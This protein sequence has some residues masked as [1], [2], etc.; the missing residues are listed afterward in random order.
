MT[1]V[2]R[3]NHDLYENGEEY[4][5]RLT[6][7][8]NTNLKI[9]FALLS[10]YWQSS[11]DG[12]NYARELKAIA[13][14]L[15]RLR[16]ALDD[17]R[18]D[19]YYTSTRSEFLYQTLTSVLFPNKVTGAPDPQLSDLDFRTFLNSILAIYFKGSVPDSIKRAVELLTTGQIT[20]REGFLEAKKPGS[21]YDISDQF[22]FAIDVIL[23]TPGSTN[24]ILADKNI[25]ILLNIIRPAHTLYRIKWII[26]DEYFGKQDTEK[27]IFSKI[28]DS[29]KEAIDLYGYSDFRRFAEGVY[30]IDTKGM[31][32]AYSAVSEP[33]L[34]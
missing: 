11:I 1:K 29:T 33:H 22:S 24:V 19:T 2:L 14:E 13:I 3:I 6:D 8:A 25:R 23:D 12:P 5:S 10:S 31:K 16:L 7:E 34:F 15:A 21:G 27:G 26:T 20:V 9:L 4:I 17:I 28:L 30:G 18:L 32:K